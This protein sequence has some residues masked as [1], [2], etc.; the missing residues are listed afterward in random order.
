MTT[1][2]HQLQG[3]PDSQV[4]KKTNW[5]PRASTIQRHMTQ[6]TE[7]IQVFTGNCPSVQEEWIGQSI[8]SRT[9]NKRNM[10]TISH[11]ATTSKSPLKNKRILVHHKSRKTK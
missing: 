5:E 2:E 10:R 7:S 11:Y 3:F 6:D 4:P 8:K 9:K 1:L